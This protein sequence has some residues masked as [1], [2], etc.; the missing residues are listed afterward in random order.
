MV[1]RLGDCWRLLV[2]NLIFDGYFVLFLPDFFNLSWETFVS[3]ER[4]FQ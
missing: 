2:L 3:K 1:V 4:V